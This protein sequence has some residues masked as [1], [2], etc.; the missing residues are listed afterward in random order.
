MYLTTISKY[1]TFE[2]FFRLS[3]NCENP[4]VKLWDNCS[5][6]LW[7]LW[8]IYMGIYGKSYLIAIVAYRKTKGN[9]SIL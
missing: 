5:Y 6:K 8:E 4:I 1:Y 2:K 9:L 3:V 7:E